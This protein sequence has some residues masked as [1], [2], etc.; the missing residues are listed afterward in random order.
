MTTSSL[1]IAKLM[2]RSFTGDTRRKQL[3]ETQ[4]YGSLHEV[5]HS[6]SIYMVFPNKRCSRIDRLCKSMND[7]C[8][9]KDK[10]NTSL[11]V[12]KAEIYR[13][14]VTFFT[15]KFAIGHGKGK[16][17]TKQLERNYEGALSI[18]S[19]SDDQDRRIRSPSYYPK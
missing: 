1:T 19:K 17:T 15:H 6:H 12:R 5:R 2:N 13:K 3:R 18:S 11:N 8:S 14:A 4:A 9:K 10:V 16:N 7:F